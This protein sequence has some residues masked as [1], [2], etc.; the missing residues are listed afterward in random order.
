MAI[1]YF[2]GQQALAKAIGV[3]RKCVNNW[4]NRDK[5]LSLEYAIKIAKAS[6][7]A[8]SISLLVPEK[9]ALIRFLQRSKQDVSLIPIEQIESTNTLP[10]QLTKIEALMVDIKQQG[11]QQP[12]VIDS[13][14]QL[15]YGV[16]RLYSCQLLG[17]KTI[18]AYL[19]SLHEVLSS[20]EYFLHVTA[21]CRLSERVCLGY[22]LEQY[23]RKQSREKQ[24]E[25]KCLLLKSCPNLDTQRHDS[26]IA[27]Y[28]G[29]GSKSNYYFLKKVISKAIPALVQAL[30]SRT[31]AIS[32]AARIALLPEVAQCMALKQA[33]P[34]R[35]KSINKNKVAG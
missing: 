2:G 18:R 34:K 6:R 25:I 19:I 13:D 16:R 28:L 15:I 29:F 3:S 35:K 27:G 10:K 12:I 24:A 9:M 20:R 4:L 8:I 32:V 23:I 21:H 31:I 17:W 33:F 30:D 14:Y 7:E 22:C 11:L 26:W 1:K 5:S